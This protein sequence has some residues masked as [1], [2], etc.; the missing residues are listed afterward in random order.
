MNGELDD[1]VGDRQGGAVVD[2][3]TFREAMT[4]FASG[5]TLVTTHDSTG[6]LH[7]YTASAFSSV[8]ADPPLV[9]TCLDKSARCHTAFLDADRFGIA[10]LRPDHWELARRFASKIEDK[11]DDRFVTDRFG[12]AR[13]P[14]AL[15]Y[16]ACEA[17]DRVSA[18]DH[19]ILIG[20]VVGAELD[21]PGE[22][23][24]FFGRNL[25]YLRDLMEEG[26]G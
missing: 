7:G 20:K 26:N 1:T 3:E 22:P 16:L 10:I 9:L 18:G 5:V 24:V 14:D 25:R 11:F 19:T 6:T 12:L 2:S 21:T 13:L 8:S 23:A 4:R 15:A 17:Y